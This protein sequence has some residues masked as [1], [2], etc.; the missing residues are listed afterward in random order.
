MNKPPHP[1]NGP[2]L[3]RSLVRQRGDGLRGAVGQGNGSGLAGLS[4][5]ALD[6]DGDALGAGLLLGLGVRLDALE[7][8]LARSGGLDV[9]D[10]DAD[11]LLDV[12]VPDL[13]VDDDTNSRL[14][15]VVDDTGLAVVDL[16]GHATQLSASF[17]ASSA[18]RGFSCCRARHS[19]SSDSLTPSEP[20]R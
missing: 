18:L 2:R 9:L 20:H 5:Q 17:C 12:P 6:L 3:N 4:R 11:S 16:V 19:V 14:G 7:E 8:V 10:S 15:D 1:A 13:L